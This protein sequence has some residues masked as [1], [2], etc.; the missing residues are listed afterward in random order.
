LKIDAV[1]ASEVVEEVYLTLMPLAQ[2]ERQVTLV[3]G[4]QP[5]LPAVQADRQ[6]LIQVL[7]NL[8]RNAITSTPAGGIVSI[9]LEQLDAQHLA[10]IVEDNGVGIPA[11]ELPRI[12]ERF[13]RA[14]ASRSRSTGGFGL[15]LA[16]VHDLVTAMGG[17]ISVE[18][19]V[20]QGSRFCVT[21]LIAA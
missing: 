1:A 11:A 15:G 7:T 21:L 9:S 17:S 4:T 20:G 13:Y 8:V 5:N 12:F 10:L 19:T 3:R 6:R 16:I 14:D 18:S 2:R